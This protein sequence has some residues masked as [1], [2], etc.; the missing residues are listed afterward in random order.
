M[1]CRFSVPIA[2]NSWEIFFNS[3]KIK[4]LLPDTQCLQFEVQKNSKGNLSL[5]VKTCS[6]EEAEQLSIFDLLSQ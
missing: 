4:Q 5:R 3:P 2:V 6:T 1:L